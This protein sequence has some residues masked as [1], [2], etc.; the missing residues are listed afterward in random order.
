MGYNISILI[1]KTLTDVR[2]IDFDEI[3]FTVDG[4]SY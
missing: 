1:G 2:K 4:G 3:I